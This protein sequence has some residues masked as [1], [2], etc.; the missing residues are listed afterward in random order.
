[1]SV[2]WRDLAA[3]GPAGD[4]RAGDE[5][6]LVENRRYLLR[7]TPAITEIE[8][9]Q[10][11]E[12]GAEILGADTALVSFR[13]YV[14]RLALRSVRFNVRSR[15][16]GSEGTAGLFARVVELA[17]VLLY[18]W[19]TP[20]GTPFH[21]FGPRRHHVRFHDLLLLRH[22][23]LRAPPGAR[24]VD[25]FDRVAE[26]P[27]RTLITTYSRVRVDRL[28]RADRSSWASI[29]LRPGALV[30]LEAGHTLYDDPLAMAL[31]HAGEGGTRRFF[32]TSI[33]APTRIN[34]FDTAENRFLKH[35]LRMC[36]GIV[37]PFLKRPDVG[38]S[39]QRDVAAMAAQ[40]EQLERSYFLDGVRDAAPTLAPT[41]ATLKL[42]GYRQLFEVYRALLDEPTLP[43]DSHEAQRFMDGR[44]VATLYEYWTFLMLL[45][46]ACKAV[47]LRTPNARVQTS[48]YGALIPRGLFVPVTTDVSVLFNASYAG[49]SKDG[50]YSTALRPDVVLRVRSTDFAFDAKYSMDRVPS[51][52]DDPDDDSADTPERLWKRADLYKMHT[53]RD[54]LGVPCA[55][56]MYPGDVFTFFER[57]AARRTSASGIEEFQGVGAIPLRPDNDEHFAGLVDL[58]RRLI[59]EGGGSGGVGD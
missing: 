13:N 53:Y 46:A 34:T 20:L 48:M 32:P 26:N 30:E 28:R 52:T 39:L 42:D 55:F 10:L 27:T 59:D 56:V 8:R 25:N 12:A 33:V 49:L 4:A 22:E 18:G 16:L 7:F 1:M 21:R 31:E 38:P 57:S 15:K 58:V 51:I 9:A 3:D 24:L 44:D 19:N 47:G 17:A 14:G 40:L 54:A 29:G 50:S 45:G 23:M 43:Q 35:L 11:T 36:Q 5:V 2:S 6:E 37:W 41:Q